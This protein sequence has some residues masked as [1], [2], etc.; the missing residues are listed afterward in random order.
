MAGINAKR[1]NLVH[2]RNDPFH[3]TM[4][5]Y[6][7]NL[8]DAP[9]LKFAIRLY[10]DAPGDPIVELEKVTVIN[11]SGV[12]V[13]DSGIEDDLPFTDLEIIIG[14]GD[15]FPA[16][17]EAGGDAVFAY[18]FEWTATPVTDGFYNPEQT[19]LFG[20]FIVKGSVND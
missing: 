6:G 7:E 1:W 3:L 16:A 19:R 17:P 18:D 11:T 8:A 14:K 10:P 4:R 13:V 20:D 2:F 15:I 9:S 5:I 12:R